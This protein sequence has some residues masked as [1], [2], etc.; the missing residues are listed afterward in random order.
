MKR[1]LVATAMLIVLALI[2]LLI[3]VGDLSLSALFSPKEGQQAAQILLISRIP[4]TLAIILAGTAMA[5]AGTIMQM[6]TRNRFVEPSTAGTVES[7]SLGLLV[8]TLFAPEAPV[9]VK[10][11][12]AS[13]FALAGTAL[14]LRI[15]KLVPLRSA[16]T[17]PLVG[18]MLGGIVGAITTFFA[19]RFDLLQSVNAW[20]TGDFSGVL[21]GRYE[22]LWVASA[23]TIFA[24]L[25]ADRLTLAGMGRD[26]ATNLGL[27]YRSIVSLGLVIVAMVTATIVVTVGML[28]FLG[29]I[30]PNVVSLMIGDN[31][32]RSL[33]W[34]ALLGAGLVLVCDIVGRVA[35]YPYEIPIGTIMGIVGSGL[36]LFLLLQGRD[37][38]A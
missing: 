26:F 14:F 13:G 29:L 10:M 24:Y 32:R 2:S 15:L 20:T 16:M 17:V 22:L 37:R 36:F 21:R 12:V 4:R 1:L 27:R 28:P 38:L 25:A 30:V 11:L 23:L 31:M 7:A 6:L 3:G 35:Y 5:V 19:Y 8:V 18:V 9:L 34:I 33:P